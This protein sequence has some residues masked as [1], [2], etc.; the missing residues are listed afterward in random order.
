MMGSWW[1]VHLAH[2]TRPQ[3]RLGRGSSAKQWA[4]CHR[5]WVELAHQ[6]CLRVAKPNLMWHCWQFWAS[7]QEGS[8]ET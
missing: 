6:W 4:G 1:G 5:G 8:S 3:C 7:S 2:S